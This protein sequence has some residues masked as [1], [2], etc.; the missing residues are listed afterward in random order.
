MALHVQR[1][2]H[3]LQH[4]L[5]DDRDQPQ[6]VRGPDP[7]DEV[8]WDLQLGQPEEGIAY[9]TVRS[10]LGSLRLLR[11]G[12]VPERPTRQAT[13]LLQLRQ[14]DGGARCAAGRYERG[15]AGGPDDLWLR[16]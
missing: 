14:A 10:R 12:R 6:R 16:G 7:P 2:E 11:L 1:R 4:A 8:G 3:G 13:G 5:R 15:A 9:P